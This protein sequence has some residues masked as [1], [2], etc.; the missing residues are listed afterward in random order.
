MVARVHHSPLLLSP[1]EFRGIP[2]NKAKARYPRSLVLDSVYANNGL[3]LLEV[4]SHKVAPV[5]EGLIEDS[6]A[7]AVDEA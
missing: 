4:L 1:L 3:I 2:D 6:L 7:V 5:F